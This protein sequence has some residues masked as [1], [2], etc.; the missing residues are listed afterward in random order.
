MGANQGRRK[1]WNPR[2]KINYF[3]PAVLYHRTWAAYLIVSCMKEA[4]LTVLVLLPVSAAFAG[5]D[6]WHFEVLGVSDLRNGRNEIVL[7]S[8]DL[9][10]PF[11]RECETISVISSYDWPW[12]QRSRPVTSEE[13]QQALQQ[14]K[15]AQATSSPL[16]FGEIGTGLLQKGNERCVFVSRGLREIEGSIYSFNKWP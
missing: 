14:L 1:S 4:I 5:G 3:A 10:V 16:R 6:S 8:L 2:A 13:H 7:K 11:A 9:N 12:W 15:K